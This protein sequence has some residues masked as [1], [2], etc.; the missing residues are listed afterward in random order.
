MLETL[1]GD[2]Q[3]LP[4]GSSMVFLVTSTP[5]T[6]L[7]TLWSP[8]VLYNSLACGTLARS[9]FGSRALLA[10]LASSMWISPLL[11][12]HPLTGERAVC[13][14]KGEVWDLGLNSAAREQIT[15]Q[16]LNASG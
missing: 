13:T 15:F 10:Q 14:V 8:V 1:L 6:E 11:E 5:S 9:K 2:T 16:V 4:V 12:T 7:N 3:L